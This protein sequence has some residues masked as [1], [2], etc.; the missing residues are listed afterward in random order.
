MQWTVAG[1]EYQSGVYNVHH[2]VRLV[3]PVRLQHRCT[4]PG[5]RGSFTVTGFRNCE[6]ASGNGLEMK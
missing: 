2:R 1:S 5:Q 6:T 3:V 4:Q